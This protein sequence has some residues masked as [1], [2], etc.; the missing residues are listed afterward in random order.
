MSAVTGLDLPGTSRCLQPP[1]TSLQMGQKPT[2]NAGGS[3]QPRS[4][5]IGL[6][7]WPAACSPVCHL[8]SLSVLCSGLNSLREGSGTSSQAPWEES[9]WAESRRGSARHDPLLTDRLS[10]VDVDDEPRGLVPTQDLV[11]GW[12][13]NT[14]VMAMA[15]RDGTRGTRVS[16][17]WR[18]RSGDL[19]TDAPQDILQ[20]PPHDARPSP[21]RLR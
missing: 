19:R 15:G 16:Y 21:P 4:S 5:D 17:G 7:A 12:K 20:V 18:E 6:K 14:K 8:F 13:G 3:G 1:A 11:L 10:G 9:R 2:A